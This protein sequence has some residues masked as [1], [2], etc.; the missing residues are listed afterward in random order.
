M[1]RLS[2]KGTQLTGFV[3]LS[4]LGEAKRD[5][6]VRTSAAAHVRCY[7][8]PPPSLCAD[9]Q[10]PALSAAGGRGDTA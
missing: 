4:Q 9:A 6:K 10:A 8:P 2:A 3:P 5:A 7:P 1:V